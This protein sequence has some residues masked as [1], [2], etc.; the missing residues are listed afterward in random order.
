MTTH[1][2]LYVEAIKDGEIVYRQAI[3]DTFDIPNEA[4]FPARCHRPRPEV[5]EDEELSETIDG[6]FF[7]VS[8][9]THS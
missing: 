3:W 4:V 9:P 7:I 8:K 2:P 5:Y 6:R 1:N